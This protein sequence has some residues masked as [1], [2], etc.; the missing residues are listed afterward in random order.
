MKP[1]LE[2]LAA[3]G[4]S[5][6][7]TMF[8][9]I[10]PSRRRFLKAIV[11]A[12][13]LTLAGLGPAAFADGRHG[14][15]HGGRDRDRHWVTTW[16]ASPVAPLP[17]N[18]TNP[19]F[20]NQT[21]RL[22][23]HTSIGGDKVRVRLSNAFGT[24]SLVVGAAHIAL[25]ASGA[26]VV[27]GSDRALTFSGHAST[28][29][30][31]G[32]LAVSDPV[33]LDVPA[34]SNLAVSIFLP[35]P[36]GQATWHSGARQTNY[37]SPQTGDHTADVVMPVESTVTS[38]FYLTNVE[39]KASEETC[40]IVT[41]GDSIT[42][43]TASTLDANHRWPNFLAERLQARH[44]KRAVVDQGIGGNRVL[45]DITGPNAQARLD[46]D[47]LAQTG[48]CSVTLLEGINDIGFPHLPPANIANLPPGTDLTDVSADEIIAGH[49]QIITRAHARGLKIF[50]AT[51]TPFEGALYFTPEGEAKR[52]AVNH[53]IRTSGEYD[54]VID[55]DKAT[56]DPANP[57]QFLPAYDSGDHLHPSDAGYEAMADAINLRLFK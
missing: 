5:A 23:V 3:F 44:F 42:D 57:T 40:A 28:T 4:R 35:G 38:W 30:P 51:L 29:I 37:V 9:A 6:K 34:L 16:G 36:T 19:G 32:A 11:A 26:E 18:T 56:R 10:G 13:A 21:V 43:G 41:L 39:V 2:F 8:P 22:I 24:S 15:D 25:Q 31:P 1:T 20:T 47:V 14:D 49:L 17:T 46:R 12:M 55:F 45:H 7:G 54:G 48:V 53:W 50:G 27:P 33:E 52:Q